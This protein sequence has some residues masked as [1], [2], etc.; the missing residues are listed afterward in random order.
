MEL[1]GGGVVRGVSEFGSV[2]VAGVALTA[3][4]VRPP[5]CAR[6]HTHTRGRPW[7]RRAR[8]SL[9]FISLSLNLVVP[10]SHSLVLPA[11]VPS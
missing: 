2:A 4:K 11:T 5:S 10:L 9:A 7:G 3:G 1:C 6:A 8:C